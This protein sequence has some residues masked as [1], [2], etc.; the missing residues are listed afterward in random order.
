MVRLN[1]NAPEYKKDATFRVVPYELHGSEVSGWEIRRKGRV[2]LRLGPG[3]TVVRS[4]YC[5]I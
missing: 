1:F 4:L 2:S 5:G 3:Y